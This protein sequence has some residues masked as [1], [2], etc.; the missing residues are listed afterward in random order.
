MIIRDTTRVLIALIVA[1]LLGIAIGASGHPALLAAADWLGP[2]G[3]LWV[4]AI[5]MT[6]IPLVVSLVITGVTSVADVRS[7]GRIGARS[8]AVFLGLLLFVAEIGRA[9]V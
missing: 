1:V 2:I 7:V 9:H 6:V 3:T 5:R 4:T 8:L